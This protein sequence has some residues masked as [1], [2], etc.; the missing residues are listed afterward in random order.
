MKICKERWIQL[1]W[2]P[3]RRHLTT[4]LVQSES[5]GRIFD[6]F[7]YQLDK[8][9]RRKGETSNS[10]FVVDFDYVRGKNHY[11]VKEPWINFLPLFIQQIMK[12]FIQWTAPNNQRSYHMSLIIIIFPHS[13]LGCNLLLGERCRS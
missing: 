12:H 1:L 9:I 11:E 8:G 7:Y 3:G 4:N 6:A 5:W 10:K 2:V 13:Y